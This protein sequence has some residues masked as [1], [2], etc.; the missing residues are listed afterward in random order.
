MAATSRMSMDAYLDSL[1]RKPRPKPPRGP[2]M[3]SLFDEPPTTN[4]ESS[5]SSLVVVEQS[6]LSAV[7]DSLTVTARHWIDQ[8]KPVAV[9]V[10]KAHGKV[11]AEMFRAEA[12][13]RGKL[14][15]TYGEQRALSWIPCMF[16]ELCKEGQLQKRTRSD[17][18]V[19]REYSKAQA[20]DQVV[21]IPA[22]A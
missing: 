22:I 19:V 14:P 11:T 8:G 13:K 7:H 12:S 20:N 18:S 6:R 16:S 4:L 3:P 2:V 5:G 1:D 17:G 10:A 21:Y 9:A 15:P